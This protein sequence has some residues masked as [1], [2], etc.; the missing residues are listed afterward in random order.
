[1]PRPRMSAVKRQREQAKRDRQQRKAE[2]RDDRK[3]QDSTDEPMSGAPIEADDPQ[4][5]TPE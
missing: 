2:R 1:M 5:V 4:P 3:R